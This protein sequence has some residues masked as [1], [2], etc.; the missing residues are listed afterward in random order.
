MQP[1]RQDTI[2]DSGPLRVRNESTI[3]KHQYRKATAKMPY[4]HR[5]T[6]KAQV[7][8]RRDFALRQSSPLFAK[9][10][11][12]DIRQPCVSSDAVSFKRRPFWKHTITM[13]IDYAR[14]SIELFARIATIDDDNL[15]SWLL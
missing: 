13:S 6:A 11:L 10:G 3:T 12:G 8:G 2:L 1:T 14:I 7:S 9:Y 15:P 4:D 5:F